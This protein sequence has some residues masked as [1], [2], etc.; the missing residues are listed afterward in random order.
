MR[1]GVTHY[2]TKPWDPETVEL[3]ARVALRDSVGT[4]DSREMNSLV[5]AGSTSYRATSGGDEETNVIKIGEQLALLEKQLGGGLTLGSLT[6]IEGATSSGTSILGQ[7]LVYGA[8][9]D[10]RRVAYFSSQHTPV[11]LA[12]QMGSVGLGISKYLQNERL[13]IYPV[14]EPPPDDDCG[15]M[16]AALA[17]DI[18]RLPKECEL[19]VVDAITNLV[20]H[21][22]EQAIIGFFS[23]CR[24]AC[25]KGK[26]VVAV[27]HSYA[28]N[29]HMFTRLSALCDA[30]LKLRVGKVRDKVVRMLE[31][32]KANSVELNRDNTISFEVESG[33]GMRIIPYSQTKG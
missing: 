9:K 14:E 25:S 8:L 15:P 23:S 22:Q 13:L 16:L 5:W 10:D 20:G 26:T 3:T 19:T 4:N 21:S 28:L 17:L 31:V 33:S 18:E 32:V 7:H 6:L 24:R 11:S 30:H 12:K 29:E 1:L 2:I 27:A